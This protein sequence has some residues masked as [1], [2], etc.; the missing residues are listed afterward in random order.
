MV[1]RLFKWIREKRMIQ[2]VIKRE[3]VLS[4][5]D[6]DEKRLEVVRALAN[7][8]EEVKQFAEGDVCAPQRL[9]DLVAGVIRAVE[10]LTSNH[11][12]YNAG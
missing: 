1:Y 3:A 12:E 4:F 2:N 9:L 6:K 5:K 7:F 10:F 11:L 8:V